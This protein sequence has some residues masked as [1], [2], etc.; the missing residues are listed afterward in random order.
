MKSSGLVW[1]LASAMLAV[2]AVGDSS[3]ALGEKEALQLDRIFKGEVGKG[4]L[5][6]VLAQYSEDLSWAKPYENIMT[7]YCKGGERC[8]PGSQRLTNVGREGHTFLHHIVENYDKL[9]DWT[10][11]SQAG[12]PTEGYLGHEIGGGHMVHGVSFND[13]L[14]EPQRSP[15]ADSFFVITS[16][17]H[18]PTMHHSLRTIFKTSEGQAMPEVN[19]LPAMCPAHEVT[20]ST[21]DAWAPYGTVPW[22]RAFV[23]ERCGLDESMLGDAVLSFWDAFVQL[24]RPPA[25]IAHFVQGARF[26]ASRERI[27]TRS[28]A[29]YTKLLS[30]VSTEADPC[31]NYLFEWAWYYIIG[32]P[33]DFACEVS[34]DEKV[35]AWEM[36]ER[37]LQA[38]SGMSGVSGTS[39]VSGASGISGISGISGASG[40]GG[41]PESRDKD[42]GKNKRG[43]SSE[44]SG[45]PNAGTADS[46]ASLGALAA[47]VVLA[48]PLLAASFVA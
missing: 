34:P 6:V 8:A 4:K 5:E 28:K 31:I 44:E 24:P 18:I 12:E 23:A 27:L 29:F 1:A 17:V 20:E 9:A 13:Y 33:S 42:S 43:D 35:Q 41:S 46:G 19:A 26:A 21:T 11:F 3:R 47:P 10:V 2:S 14:L 45:P 40:I 37:L 16:K 22:L 38:A 7:V 39:G 30:L 15:N 36:E 32:T 48:V 25:N